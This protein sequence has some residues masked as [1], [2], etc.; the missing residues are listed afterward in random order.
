MEF[1]R[2]FDGDAKDLI[3]PITMEEIKEAVW[4]C[5]SFKVPDPD[6][7]N[8]LFLKNAWEIL[9]NNFKKIIDDFCDR[10][11]LSKGVNNFFLTLIPKVEGAFSLNNFRPIS[12]INGIYKVVAKILTKRLL[13]VISPLI[14]PI[15]AR[16]LVGCQLL[17]SVMIASE[18]IHATK[19][20]RQHRWCLKVDFCKVY[21]PECWGALLD[22][23]KAM[24]FPL[25]WRK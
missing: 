22:V 18:T 20:S 25:K 6:G 8:F 4:D 3:R 23:S 7:F 10:E 5:G 13:R 21:D 14:S 12:L 9:T 1:N 15:Q 19:S 24:G 17:D 2:L 16:F 11:R